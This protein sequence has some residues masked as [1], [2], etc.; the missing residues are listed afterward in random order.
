MDKLVEY[1]PLLIPIIVLQLGLTIA[2]IVHILR[3]KTY[4]IGNRTIWILVSFI[5]IIGPI[6]YFVFG[7]GDE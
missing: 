7:R 3:H 2:A 6:A 1:L 4:R 5:Q